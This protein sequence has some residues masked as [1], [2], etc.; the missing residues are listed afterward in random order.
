MLK[1]K[2]FGKAIGEAIE[3]K[4]ELGEVRSKAEIARH[5]KMKPS[6]LADWVNKGSISKDKLNE[7]YR[8]FSDVVSYDHWGLTKGEWPS[9]LS[10][11]V[12]ESKTRAS[13]NPARVIQLRRGTDHDRHIKE[14]IEL[15]SK[16]DAEGKIRCAALVKKE[17]E[18]YTKRRKARVKKKLE[19]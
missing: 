12:K 18:D 16:T 2:D 9:E 19:Q 14:V 17:I 10:E 13:Q 7:L 8:Y 3:K 4:L 11:T 6:S 1:G 15:M 5:F